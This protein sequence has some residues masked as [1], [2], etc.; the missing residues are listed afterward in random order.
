MTDSSSREAL[1][2][3]RQRIRGLLEAGD[4]EALISFFWN[5]SP[6]AILGPDE[7]VTKGRSILLGPE[8]NPFSLEDAERAFS[9]ALEIDPTYLPALLELAWFYYAVQDDSPRA[10]PLFERALEISRRS[11]T[12]AARG[13]AGCLAETE[14]PVAAAKFLRD[15]HEAAL[16]VERLDEEQQT[17]LEAEANPGE[18]QGGGSASREGR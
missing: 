14:S 9:Q 2:E 4:N 3:R 10:A 16:L 11:L 6:D 7:L 8:D 17:W 1:M 12:E 13:L 18:D 15:L 5:L